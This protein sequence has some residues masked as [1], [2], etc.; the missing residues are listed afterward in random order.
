MHTA[1]TSVQEALF[2]TKCGNM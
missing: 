2:L 1:D